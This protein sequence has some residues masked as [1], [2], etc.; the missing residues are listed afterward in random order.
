MLILSLLLSALG[1]YCAVGMLF[2]VLFAFL[3]AK[4]IDPGAAHGTL[5]FKL[6]IIPGCAVFWPYLL[7][8]WLKK[9]P[10]PEEFSAHRRT[11][12]F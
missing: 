11:A 3:G 4:V 6:V 12:K 10:P 8:R 1:I 9:S 2:G 7:M 5:G